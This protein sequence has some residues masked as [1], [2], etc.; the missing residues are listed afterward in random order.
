MYLDHHQFLS[1]DDENTPN[2][3]KLYTHT[4]SGQDFSQTDHQVIVWHK[5]QI[6]RISWKDL[7]KTMQ[8][9]RATN[10]EKNL[11]T[12]SH[13]MLT[14]CSGFD[15]QQGLK[16][17][18]FPKITKERLE[19]LA[20]DVPELRIIDNQKWW[21]HID[22]ITST[23][24]LYQLRILVIVAGRL[25]IRNNEFVSVKVQLL[26]PTPLS[27]C[28]E[29]IEWLIHDLQ[30]EGFV[31]ACYR[32]PHHNGTTLEITTHDYEILSYLKQHDKS[33]ASVEK[34]FTKDL[35]DQ[36]I[37]QLLHHYPD[38]KNIVDSYWIKLWEVK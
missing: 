33:L 31:I 26:I 3:P 7:G 11:S 10:K 8:V 28:Q 36:V 6:K 20:Q 1:Y 38:S 32:Q 25:S 22:P 24:L 18:F 12:H 5:L 35:T 14:V 9:I 17:Y 27:S 34:I 4:L 37:E 23:D 16:Y 13:S 21:F 2:N 15:E 19:H 30:Q 29:R